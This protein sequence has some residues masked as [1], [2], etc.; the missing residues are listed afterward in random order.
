MAIIRCQRVAWVTLAC[1][2]SMHVRNSFWWC[3]LWNEALGGGAAQSCI[4]TLRGTRHKDCPAH[5][6]HVNAWLVSTA[7]WSGEVQRLPH[8]ISNAQVGAVNSNVQV[9][10]VDSI[11]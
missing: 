7:K 10:E 4:L 2:L 1:R 9:G 3:E 5:S 6:L 11:R 8:S